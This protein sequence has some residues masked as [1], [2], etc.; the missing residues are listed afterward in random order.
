[1]I[2]N[3]LIVWFWLCEIETYL[4]HW[5]EGNER[6]NEVWLLKVSNNEINKPSGS[7]TLW[8]QNGNFQAADEQSE[9]LSHEVL[10]TNEVII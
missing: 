10:E 6:R 9:L 4:G 1:M 5:T 8:N 7:S 3:H 2:K